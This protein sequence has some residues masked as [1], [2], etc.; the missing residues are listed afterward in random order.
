M[1]VYIRK[2]IRR[3]K[4][5]KKIIHNCKYNKMVGCDVQNCARCGWNP[6]VEEKRRRET[7]LGKGA[8]V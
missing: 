5:M 3:E 7:R 2:N 4:E 8:K 1:L 6:E